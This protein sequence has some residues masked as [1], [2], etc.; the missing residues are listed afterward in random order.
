M[1]IS[2]AFQFASCIFAMVFH[3]ILDLKTRLGFYPASLIFGILSRIL[4]SGFLIL[5][6]CWPSIQNFPSADKSF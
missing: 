4:D 2:E 6:S 1:S 3:R 5:D